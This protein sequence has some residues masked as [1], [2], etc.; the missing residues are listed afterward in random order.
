MAANRARDAARQLK[1]DIKNTIHKS[2]SKE[3]LAPDTTTT[4][5]SNGRHSLPY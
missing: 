4:T 3:R 5:T 1:D 2:R